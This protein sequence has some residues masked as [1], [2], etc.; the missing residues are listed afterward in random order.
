MPLHD[1]V[2]TSDYAGPGLDPI[3]LNV[4]IG[5]SRKFTV[6]A[7]LN[8][9]LLIVIEAWVHFSYSFVPHLMMLGNIVQVSENGLVEFEMILSICKVSESGL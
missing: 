6:S 8:K 5:L 7:G 4:P 1:V 2:D 3:R 9:D